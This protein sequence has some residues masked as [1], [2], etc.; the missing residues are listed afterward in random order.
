MFLWRHIARAGQLSDGRRVIWAGAGENPRTSALASAL[1][2]RSPAL[3]T[4]GA[5][6]DS[7]LENLRLATGG[8]PSESP[9]L[10]CR[11]TVCLVAVP[12]LVGNP[13]TR[14]PTTIRRTQNPTCESKSGET[15]EN[16][17]GFGLKLFL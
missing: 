12:H 13:V 14:L 6:V 5:C 4:V 7:G 16:A 9:E 15:F 11:S 1:T 8:S 3:A 10:G 2:L 17:L